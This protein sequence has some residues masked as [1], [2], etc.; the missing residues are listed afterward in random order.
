M[1]TKVSLMQNDR[2][3]VMAVAAVELDVVLI[4][5]GRDFQYSGVCFF[6]ISVKCNVGKF[7]RCCFDVPTNKVE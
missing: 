1:T 6:C 7:D 4:L 5:S 3:V 2:M